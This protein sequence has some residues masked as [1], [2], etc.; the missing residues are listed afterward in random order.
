[1]N[2]NVMQPLEVFPFRKFLQC[3]DCIEGIK[4]K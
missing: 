3:A 2:M 1:M 4:C